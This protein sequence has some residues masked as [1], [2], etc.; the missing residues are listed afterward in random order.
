MPISANQPARITVRTATIAY[1]VW[2]SP[3]AISQ[4]SVLLE[5]VR[6]RIAVVDANVARLHAAHFPPALFSRVELI[7]PGETSKSLPTAERLY[8]VLADARV[9]RGDM[10]IAIGGGVVTDLAGFVAGTWLRGIRYISIPTTLEAAIDASVGGKT[11]I[12]HAAGKNLIGVFHHPSTVLIDTRFLATLPRRDLIAGLAES[13]KHALLTTPAFVAWHETHA[14]LIRDGDT[15]AMNELIARN[16]QVKTDVV[17]RDER[18]AGLRAILNYGHTIG[19]AIEHVLEYELRH[20]E[21]VALGIVAENA[22]AVAAG[23]LDPTTA[24]R[25]R[26]LLHTLGLPTALPRPVDAEALLEACRVD[27]KVR[28]GKVRFALLRGIGAP[29]IVDHLSDAEIVGAIR[30]IQP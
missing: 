27:K 2:I 18:E 20:G 14:E 8:S 28:S 11:A 19:H 25:A 4:L 7:E 5:G 21:C 3:E 13:V 23:I 17:A 15:G 6:T 12:N 24:T 26:A 29:V 30:T 10:L 22:L 1:D 9:E 16:I